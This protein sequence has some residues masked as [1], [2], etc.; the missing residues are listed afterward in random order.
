MAIADSNFGRVAYVA[1]STFGTTPATPTMKIVRMTSSDFTASKETVMS[2]ELRTDRMVSTL[3]ETAATSAGTIN[4]E[5]S[6]GGSFDDFFEAALGGTWGTA[7]NFTGSA[8]FATP[9]NTITA[10]GAFTNVVVGQW[11]YVSDAVDTVNNGWHKV[12]AKASAN[13]VTVATSLAAETADTVTIKAKLLRNGTVKRS[14]SVEQ[15][16]LDVNQFFLFRGQRVSSLALNVSAGAITTGSFGFM[17]TSVARAGTTYANSL[18]N[19]TTTEVVNA[20]S[21]VGS[22]SEGGTELATAVQSI[23]LNLDN[24]LRNQNAVKSKFPV[25]IG[26]GRQVVTGTVNAYFEDGALYD[27]FLAHT[28]TSLSFDFTDGTNRFRVT[29]PKVFFTSNNPMPGGIDQDVMQ[30]LA[31]TAVADAS[32]ACQIQID[33]A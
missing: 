4:F 16:F 24:T 26:Y 17:G 13:E 3:S 15:A 11:I 33:V 25:G 23:S 31:F 5:L 12:T 29:L 10:T 7:T 19:P 20:T 18:T 22:I 27:K 30:E 21:N 9:A 2:S 6:L 14:F 1:E 28:S 8:D 32:T